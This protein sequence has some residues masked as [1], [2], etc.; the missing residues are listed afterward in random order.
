MV[1][2][3]LYGVLD[4]DSPIINRFND[5][6]LKNLVTISSLIEKEIEKSN[7]LLD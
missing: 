3:K 5:S 6:D 1:N 2:N 4:I 7:I